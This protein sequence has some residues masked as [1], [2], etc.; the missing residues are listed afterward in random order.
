MSRAGFCRSC[1]KNVWLTPSGDGDCGHPA[2]HIVNVYETE[3]PPAAVESADQVT[4]AGEVD[5]PVAVVPVAAPV[6]PKPRGGFKRF[7]MSPMKSIPVVLVL[8]AL[9]VLGVVFFPRPKIVATGLEVPSSTVSGEDFDVTVALVNNGWVKGAQELTIL[10]DGKPVK[11]ASVE[12]PAGAEQ[13]VRVTLS[14]EQAPGTYEISLADWEGLGGTVQILT[15]AIF[16]IG[17]V[18]VTPNSVDINKSKDARVAV[19]VLNVGEAGGNYI[20]KLMVDGELSEEREVFVPRDSDVEE[21]FSISV[22]EPGSCE[23]MVEDVR[24]D[25]AVHALERQANGKVLTNK[26]SGGK[27]RVKITNNNG[28]DVVVVLAKAGDEDSA[29]LAVYVRGGSSHTMT[30]LKD[31][32]Y[33]CYYVHGADWCTHCKAFTRSTSYGRFEQNSVLKSSGSSYTQSSVTFGISSGSGTPTEN[34][35]EGDFPT[36]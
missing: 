26:I 20:L 28:Q 12:L 18:D 5:A 17:G 16:E 10:L 7:V 21:L 33:V 1:G 32:T 31:G 8:V 4:P 36:M 35:G 14:G 23:V 27:N 9:I 19:R 3:M 6:K 2:D 25:L 22:E 24:F 11:T 34:V 15:P 30:G 29:L 13:E